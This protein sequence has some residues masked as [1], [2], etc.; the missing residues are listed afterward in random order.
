MLNAISRITNHSSAM[1]RANMGSAFTLL[2]RYSCQ[3]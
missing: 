1:L 2:K 3:A